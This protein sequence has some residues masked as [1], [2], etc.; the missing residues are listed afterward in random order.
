[1]GRPDFESAALQSVALGD[2]DHPQRAL[3][4]ARLGGLT[5]ADTLTLGARDTA[6]LNLWRRWLGSSVPCLDTCPACTR[7]V[8][9]D[10]PIAAITTGEAPAPSGSW[11]CLT[12]QDLIGAAGLEPDE[13]RRA[14]TTAVTGIAHPDS[15]LVA[16]VDRWLERH[17]PMA[18]VEIEL[19]CAFCAERWERPFDIVEHLWIALHSAGQALLREIHVLASTYHWSERDILALP[20]ARRRAYIAMVSE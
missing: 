6:L 3:A 11:R 18:R 9:F 20:R 1:V 10:L 8:S 7:E 5:G 2:P 15:A 14:L 13:A 17:D 4:L 19:C 12:T 16:E